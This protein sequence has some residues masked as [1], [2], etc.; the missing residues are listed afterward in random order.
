M[1][2][3]LYI[4]FLLVLQSCFV[5]KNV[6]MD[7]YLDENINDLD[8]LQY[9]VENDKISITDPIILSQK[10][11]TE[12]KEI[13]DVKDDRKKE[14]IYN[15]IN[16]VDTTKLLDN[17]FGIIAYNVPQ[18]FK[19][20]KYSTI[21]LRISKDKKI[22]SVVVGDRNIPIVGTGS[23]DNVILETIKIDEYITAKLYTDDGF[24]E[25]DLI[26]SSNQR[27]SDDGYTE[28]IWRVRPLK[29][30]THYIKMLI[31]ISEKDIVVYEKNIEVESDF[32]WS[33]YNWFVKWW[34]VIMT[35]IVTPILIPLIIWLWK[36]RKSE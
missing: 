10:V 3:Y 22:E 27:I 25:V 8:S 31:S 15:I 24:F 29:S 30:G 20:N 14:T 26:S 34:Q 19:V 33:F 32:S 35:T 5:N 7:S 28:W 6:T 21:K 18:S 16:Y 4:F 36:K 9:I 1:K 17:S 11:I 13:K 12:N 2:F 23:N